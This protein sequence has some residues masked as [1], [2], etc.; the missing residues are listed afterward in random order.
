M[1]NVT[2][3][4]NIYFNAREQL[5][6]S[7]LTIRNSREDDFSQTL[8]IFPLPDESS[9]ANE[10]ENLNTVITKVNRIAVEKYDSKWLDDSFLLLAEAEYLKRDFYNAIEYD[11]YVSI[12]FPDE[13]KNKIAAYLGQVKSDFALDLNDEADSVLKLAKALNFKYQQDE[14]EASQAELA[15]R[16]NNLPE[17][18]DHLSKA[19]G[20]TKEKYLKTRWRYILAQ[21][22]EKNGQPDKAAFNYDKIAKSNAAFEISF[23][24][25]LSKIRITENQQGKEFDKIAT[26]KRLLKED[27]N[28]EFKEQIYYQIG[29]AYADK[30][31]LANA[32]L[33][34]STSAHTVPGTVKQKGL[35]YLKLAQ[36]NFEQL[37]DYKKSQLYYDST[38]Q[39]LPKTYPGYNE[40]AVKANN[41]QYLADRLNIIDDQKE[42][43]QLS[44]L[45]EDDL[46]K[47]LDQKFVVKTALDP[48][49][50]SIVNSGALTSIQDFSASNKTAGTFYFYNNAALSQGLSSFKQ[51][52]GNRKLADN[53]RISDVSLPTEA[54][55]NGN[56]PSNLGT[57]VDAD[58]STIGENVDSL[59][60]RFI[61]TIPYSP[62]QKFQAN[63]KIA[64]ALYE[65]AGFYKDV[66]K[67]NLEAVEAY[68]AIVLNY[69]NQENAASIYYQLYRLTAAMDKNTSEKY[70]QELLEKYP[71][72]I[73]AKTILDPN[74]GKDAELLKQKIKDYY[75]AVYETYKLKKYDEV[76]KKIDDLKAKVDDFKE[77]DA[78]YAY[79]KSLAIGHTQKAPVFLASLNEIATNY[80]NDAE[81]TP[82]VK[83]Q[84]S[85]IEA[86][87]T[88]FNLRPTA[89]IDQDGND[90]LL[91][92]PVFVD[93][94]K[95]ED[96]KP[97]P[98]KV[99]AEAK[100]VDEPKQ[101]KPKV[102]EPKKEE[103]KEEIK[104]VEQV[105]KIENP[106]IA[107]PNNEVG[108]EAPIVPEV[109]KPVPVA[110]EPKVIVPE[111][112]KA[113]EFTDNTRQK[114]FI[115]IDISD[116]K[117]NIAQPF[118][119]LS[120]YFYSKFDPSSVRLVIRVVG[121][122]EK[123]III[124]GDFY[125]Q[126]EVQTVSDDLN[127]SLPKIMEGQTNLYQK[128][129]VSESNLKLLVS[130]D[131]IDQYLKFISK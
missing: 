80:P 95:I 12:T 101:E 53:W 58:I 14:L 55:K 77:M 44:N 122:T 97:E 59:K 33:F 73:Y 30:N 32:D 69:P 68:E 119:K 75:D 115:V 117:Q 13:K 56:Y 63:N 86:N 54:A 42:L 114:Y 10:E 50:N 66:L 112:P 87:Q 61:R 129:V 109:L 121:G 47:K 130:K 27:K 46:A 71:G 9:S 108:K 28:Q 98:I 17:A 105:T 43:L 21:L 104:P 82:R 118:S 102:T 74:Y 39:Y 126:Q 16:K 70:K 8:S 84:I 2:A 91:D 19:V 90:Y 93:I 99:V 103:P 85:F 31:D 67:D 52:W 111:K 38:L 127:S 83:K 94:P 40:I 100:K 37:K 120:Q 57:G 4:Y 79:L 34:Y 113:I 60:A 106:A 35:S 65:I 48:N 22:Q 1:K 62:Y 7:K 15:L 64:K 49:Q 124:S 89:L 116:P 81:V 26:L 11:S 45:S 96:K 107:I 25:N 131:A 78:K 88:A 3:H 41:L 29:N 24:A 5:K 18:I 110:E 125:T 6:E 76:L 23:N 72:S 92:R 123:F 36:I 20:Q 128:F 51:K